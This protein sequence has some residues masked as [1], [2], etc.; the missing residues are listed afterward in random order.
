MGPAVMLFG[1]TA[2]VVVRGELDGLAK[3][4]GLYLVDEVKV[5]L[6]P[7]PDAMRDRL[8]AELKGGAQEGVPSNAV[9]FLLPDFV[10]DIGVREDRVYLRRE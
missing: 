2:L 6:V 9:A 7:L 8:L 1:D 3:G 4:W 10:T 5:G